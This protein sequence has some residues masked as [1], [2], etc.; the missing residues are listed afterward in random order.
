MTAPLHEVAARVFE[1]PLAIAGGKAVAIV[2]AIGPRLLGAPVIVLGDDPRDH[3]AF[4]GGRPS[5]ARLGDITG[6]A[7]EA[8]RRKFYNMAGNVAIIP[9][10]GTMVHKGNYVGASSGRTSYQG[11]QAQIIRA[12]RDP[13]VAGVAFEVDSFGGEVAGMFETADMIAQLSVI[14]PTMAIL[15]DNALSAAYML[16]SAAR[17]I[18]M[19][20]HGLAGSIGAILLHAD[21]SEKQ[22]KDGVKVTVLRAGARKA[23]MNPFE[24]LP[25]E[26]RARAETQLES[27]RQSFAERVGKYRGS[28]FNARQALAT[29][30]QEFDGVDAV[31]IGL[32]DAVGRANDAFDQFVRAMAGNGRR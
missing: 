7:Y 29:E 13:A 2:E 28:R 24:A 31:S 23:T 17:Q 10:E 32:A 9:I 14:K 22:A 6:R 25:E 12:A 8:E 20:Q 15:T 19:P 4:E 30:G 3:V 16:A 21:A 18:V 26:T 11:M 1:T 5:A 27:I